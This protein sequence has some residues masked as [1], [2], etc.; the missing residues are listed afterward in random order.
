MDNKENQVE[1]S[2]VDVKL[3][4]TSEIKKPKPPKKK[5]KSRKRSKKAVTN[6]NGKRGRRPLVPFPTVPLQTALVIAD[7]IQEHAASQKTRR[8]TLFEKLG[9]SPDSGPSRL[10]ITNSSRYGLTR[11]NYTSEFI[12]LT[13]LGGKATSP[14]ISEIERIKARFDIGIDSIP[15]FSHLYQKN[16]N[17]RIPSPEIMRDSVAEF[18][19]DEHDRKECVEIFLENAKHLGLLRTIAGAERLVPIEQVI[20]EGGGANKTN[21]IVTHLERQPDN[22]IDPKGKKDWKR[23]CFF[24]APIGN[25]GQEERK[26]SDMILESLI[27]RG[28][29]G[30]GFEVIR[31]DR[32]TDPGMISGQVIE[33]LLHSAL[34]VADLSFHNPNVFYELAIRHMVGKPTI[35]LIRSGDQIPFDVKDFRT[36]VINTQDKYDLVAKLDTYRAEIANQVRIAIAGAEN[37][38]N[39]IKAFARNLSVSYG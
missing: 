8:L 26:H 39:P 38:T 1:E 2:E 15:P 17:G 7:A 12:E 33:Y 37:G 5:A 36:I 6:T 22:H 27:T 3:A 10:M 29:E 34:V 32:I 35:H 21:G 28:L 24:I 18:G 14:E 20:E 11:G 16:R 31:A 30:E 19:I 9:R 23:I 13:E 4:P 25:E